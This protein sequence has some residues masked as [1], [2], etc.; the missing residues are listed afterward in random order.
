MRNILS[1][2]F[3]VGIHNDVKFSSPDPYFHREISGDTDLDFYHRLGFS[4]NESINLKYNSLILGQ[5][6][7]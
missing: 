4:R 5:E 7:L 3:K 2:I 1:N 6:A